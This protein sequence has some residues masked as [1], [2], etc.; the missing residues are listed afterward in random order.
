MSD[1]QFN[2]DDLN[3]L[4]EGL[5][6]EIQRLIDNGDAHY[7]AF[8]KNEKLIKN[9]LKKQKLLPENISVNRGLADG[10]NL[11]VA[12]EYAHNN[13]QFQDRFDA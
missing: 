11:Q 7:Q 8:L 4:E 10:E 2:L 3:E 13:F 12:L 9:L 5:G 6:D 1:N